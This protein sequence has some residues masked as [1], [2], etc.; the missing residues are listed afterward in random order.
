ML[1]GVVDHQRASAMVP[2]ALAIAWLVLSCEPTV[3][4]GSCAAPPEAGAGTGGSTDD[5]ALSMPWSTSFED[6]LCGYH[7]AGGFCYARHGA[8]LEIVE[9]P[10]RHMGKFAAAFTV[11]A[12][13]STLDR[14]QTR[15]VREGIMPPSAYYGAWYFIPALATNADNWNLFHFLGGTS[16]ADPDPHP[17]WDISLAN[18]GG[19]LELSVY[20]FLHKTQRLTSGVDPVP[21]GRWFRIRIKIVRSAQANGEIIVLQDE[22]VALHLIDLTTDDTEWGQWYVGNFVKTLEPKLSTLYVDDITISEGP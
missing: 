16:K 12:D 9:P 14:S 19:N 20:D 6:G 7:T 10:V 21:I 15:C 22:K 5:N 18:A 13:D 4:I 11:T 17:L 8:S 3:V 2:A 1:S